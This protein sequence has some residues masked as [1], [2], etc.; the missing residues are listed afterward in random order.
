MKKTWITLSLLL[1]A[2]LGFAQ[3]E[4]VI[5]PPPNPPR[6]VVDLTQTLSPD[7]QQALEAKLVACSS[8]GILALGALGILFRRYSRE[9]TV[10]WNHEPDRC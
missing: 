1:S 10:F 3:I 4:K 2:F 8:V 7:Q 9:N 5:P 6:L